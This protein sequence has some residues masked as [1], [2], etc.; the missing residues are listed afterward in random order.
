MEILAQTAQTGESMPHKSVT[1]PA[2]RDRQSTG[3]LG[4]LL[5]GLISICIIVTGVRW[6]SSKIQSKWENHVG[7]ACLEKRNYEKAI[8]CFSIVISLDP[9]NAD[10]CYHR[11]LA[12]S[13][14]GDAERAADDF[15]IVKRIEREEERKKLEEQD[16]E[17][18][19]REFEG[20]VKDK[21]K[22]AV[23]RIIENPR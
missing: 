6:I 5:I 8:E 21:A 17:R 16:R 9:D 15:E 14:T 13:K 18:E 12:Y 7:V 11:G 1:F 20:R 10:A 2:E 4:C 3:C 19:A 22:R 23:E